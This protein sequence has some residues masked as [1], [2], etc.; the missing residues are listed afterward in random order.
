MY[1]V[2]IMSNKDNVIMINIA[3]GK[4]VGAPNAFV[5]MPAKNAP[6]VSPNALH[7]IVL[8]TKALP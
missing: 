2:Q 5:S 6:M 8:S 3:I 1:F 4:T 7:M